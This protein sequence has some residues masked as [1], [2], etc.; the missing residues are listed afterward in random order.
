M[1]EKNP[2][3]FVLCR[4]AV[5]AY[6]T[7]VALVCILS[8][9]PL[10][11]QYAVR[12]ANL[13]Y[14]ARRADVIFQ[15]QVT[16]VKH[17]PLPGYRNIRTVRVTLSVERAL[18]GLPGRTYTFR[19]VYLGLRLPDG[20]QTYRTGQRLFLFMPS[21]S[22]Y[23][24]SSPIGIGQ[25]RFHIAV[26]AAGGA[27]LANEQGNA[28]LF[29]DVERD[30]GRAGKKLTANQRKLASTR[31]GSVPLEEFVSLVKSLTTLPRI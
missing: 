26:D 16:D 13:A 29:R 1:N 8:A 19:E 6:L 21:P 30:A 7:A 3:R 12:P 31:G 5:S 17:E 14:L 27:K 25:G 20:K 9:S 23:G 4:K 15:G 2:I 18:R 24:L 28:G 22:R 11:A 10:P